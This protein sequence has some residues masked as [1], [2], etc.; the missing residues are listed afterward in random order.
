ME[1]LREQ[2]VLLLL[3][4]PP[5]TANANANANANNVNANATAQEQEQEQ[6]QQEQQPPTY[7]AVQAARRDGM[8]TVVVRRGSSGYGFRLATQDM[9]APPVIME[10]MSHSPA[11]DA[12]HPADA[13]YSVRLCNHSVTPC[14]CCCS[15][16]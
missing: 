15:L 13:I 10:V 2:E 9:A 7:D 11:R 1:L 6:E 12:L 14:C 4:S 3:R 5:T 8:R 16:S